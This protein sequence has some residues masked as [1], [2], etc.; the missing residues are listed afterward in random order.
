MS[1]SSRALERQFKRVMRAIAAICLLASCVATVADNAAA[2]LSVPVAIHCILVFVGTGL[3]TKSRVAFGGIFLLT[4]LELI[5]GCIVPVLVQFTGQTSPIYRELGGF[6]DAILVLF[7]GNAFYATVLCITWITTLSQGPGFWTE[8]SRRAPVS[9]RTGTVLI[10]L[11]ALGLFMRFPSVDSIQGFLSG[12]YEDLQTAL[13]GGLV[14]FASAVLRPLLPLGIAF[15]LVARRRIDITQLVL[16]GLL[17]VT[18]YFAL[19]SFGLN[20]AT[21]LFPI[22]ALFVALASE[23]IR[24]H[25]SIVWTAAVGSVVGFFVLGNVRNVL[26]AE[27][28]GQTAEPTSPLVSAVQTLLIYGQ[29]P[30]QSAPALAAAKVRSE[31]SIGSL[32]NSLLSPIPGVSDEIRASTGTA[33]YN[34]VLYHNATT[35]DQILP[36]WLEGFLSLGIGGT[37]ALGLIVA[38]AMRVLDRARLHSRSL[39]G[40]YASAIATI[41]L[42]QVSIN[43]VSGAVQGIIYFAVFPA[44]L[45]L[46]PLFRSGSR[47]STAPAFRSRGTVGIW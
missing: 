23:H 12:R 30:L 40:A 45:A 4:A 16:F 10:A 18:G 14:G 41:W 5:R 46:L 34:R 38:L 19:G 11:G 15:V 27:R 13:G 37:I 36:S 17:G 1:Q 3:A 9:I 21:I 22:L 44:L 39:L 35:R 24:V 43:S 29:S 28:M 8:E 25:A 26:Y 42:A 20:R 47:I 33:I 2:L 7:I 32:V 31:W 6:S